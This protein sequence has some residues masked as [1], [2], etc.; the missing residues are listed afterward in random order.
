MSIRK[1]C[2]IVI[3]V[4]F[5]IQLCG[6]VY[7]QPLT[8]KAVESI[9]RSANWL[10]ENQ[11]GNGGFMV[12]MA[13]NVKKNDPLI[14]A[15]ASIVLLEAYK[16]SHEERFL[17]GANKTLQLLGNWQN[18]DGSWSDR[19]I[20]LA[21][22]TYYPIASFAKYELYT[23]KLNYRPML[24][25]AVNYLINYTGKYGE[26][27]PY[28]F[29]LAEYTYA[30]LLAWRATNNTFYLETAEK[31]INTLIKGFNAKEGAWFT[32]IA[33]LGWGPQGMWD[34]ALP[35]LILTVYESNELRKCLNISIEWAYKHLLAFEGGAYKASFLYAPLIISGREVT[36]AVN[37][38]PHF[39]AEFLILSSVL[40]DERADE[41]VKWLLSMQA[42]NGGFFYLKKPN[43]EVE[44]ETFIWDTFWVVQGLCTYIDETYKRMASAELKNAE[45]VVKEAEEAEINVLKGKKYLSEALKAYEKLNYELSLNYTRAAI[46]TTIESRKAFRLLKTAT[47]YME[48]ASIIGVNITRFEKEIEEARGKYGLGMYDEAIKKADETI[49][50]IREAVNLRR[51]ETLR[52]LK[53]T[54]NFIYNSMEKGGNFS[55]AKKH[56]EEAYKLFEEGRYTEARDL[57]EEARK[58]ALQEL[59]GERNMINIQSLVLLLLTPTVVITLIFTLTRERWRRREK[60]TV[61]VQTEYKALLQKYIVL[62][63]EENQ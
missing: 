30:V 22:G 5:F 60:A 21:G 57:A 8:S 18:S 28:I 26:K 50:E 35:A 62:E 32:K 59:K 14:L 31:W 16:L 12:Q 38:Y 39:S 56:L 45:K 44:N 51:N 10:L 2:L 25:K 23:G 13:S 15:C 42:P 33:W 63:E 55:I 19:S 29:E 46:K 7:S 11:G 52:V 41:T 6:Q 48:N 53:E 20:F 43:G 37:A 1:G 9:L 4:L 54:E 27:Q 24:V 3:L 40:S 34:A 36:D 61:K 58:A 17:Y 47:S 49:K